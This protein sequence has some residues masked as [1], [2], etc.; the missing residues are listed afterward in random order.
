M[1]TKILLILSIL[2]IS[3]VLSAQN[4]TK[5]IDSFIANVKSSAIKTDFTL[6]VK[7]KNAKEGHT[8]KGNFTMKSN[9][10][11]MNMNEMTVYFNGKTQWAYTPQTEEVTITEPTTEELAETNPMAIL[12]AYRESSDIKFAANNSNSA[13][14]VIE[15]S[16][17]NK[18]SDLQKITV[19]IDKKTG[20][21]LSI[22]QLEKNG[23][24]VTVNLTNYQSKVAIADNAFTFDVKK[25]KNLM[26]NDLR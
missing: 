24:S 25:Y 16:P 15:L 7:E 23:N 4:A 21:L 1:K 6:V 8:V 18:K 3:N 11:I 10:F 22:K 12:Y 13:N 26:I 20:N 2:L 9:K 5:I 17:K 14:Y 19:V